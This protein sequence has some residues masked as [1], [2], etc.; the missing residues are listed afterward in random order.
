MRKTTAYMEVYSGIKKQIRDEVYKP[1]MMLPAESE[2]EKIYKVSRITVRKAIAMLSNEGYV[3]VMQGKGTEV[4]DTS[5]IQRLNSVTSITET[6]IHK[7]YRM[8][9]RG[10]AIEEVVPPAKVL[11][12]MKLEQGTVMYCLQRIMCADEI[13]I[14]IMTNYLRR[15]NI[16]DFKQHLNSFIGLY[17]FLEETYGIVVI[18][19]DEYISA[20]NADFLES[21]I[22]G[23]SMGTALLC[24]RRVSYTAQGVFE[25]AIN[26]L[27]GDRYEFS[28]H[29]VG[30]A[31]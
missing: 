24:S 22:L 29:L 20:A 16:P 19:S 1:G 25:Y 30:R 5:T 4:C 27:I 31:R 3:N 13:P 28:V 15:E 12:E 11:E 21:Q 26:K 7:G 14:A 18:K 6:F 2:L 8:S 9:V 10:M 23:V 17:R